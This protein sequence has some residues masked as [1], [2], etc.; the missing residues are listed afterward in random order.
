MFTPV[1]HAWFTRT[2]LATGCPASPSAGWAARVTDSIIADEHY[3]P[4]RDLAVLLG[5]SMVDSDLS[6]PAEADAC[7]NLI[8]HLD[9]RQHTTASGPGSFFDAVE[10][11]LRDVLDRRAARRDP[12]TLTVSLGGS[13]EAV[14]AYV[15]LSSALEEYASMKQESARDDESQAKFADAAEQLR[16]AAEAASDGRAGE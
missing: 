4:V 15:V 11:R 10:A 14:T 3:D 9:L 2:L 7:L 1:S 8:G 12:H 16:E 6:S 5:C 13:E